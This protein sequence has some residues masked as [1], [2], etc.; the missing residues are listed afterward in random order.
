MIVTVELRSVRQVK[1]T[2]VWYLGCNK[3]FF[4]FM[5]SLIPNV[6]MVWI[7]VI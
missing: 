5:L 6:R 3:P 7:I 1:E 2:T 4:I